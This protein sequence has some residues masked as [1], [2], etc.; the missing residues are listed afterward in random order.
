MPHWRAPHQPSS[1]PRLSDLYFLLFL[2]A[3]VMTVLLMIALWA[4]GAL[5]AEPKDVTC[6]T[7]GQPCKILVLTPQEEQLLIKPNGVLDSAA[8]GRYLDLGNIV[9]Y[10]R[11]KL[12][13]APQGEVKSVPKPADVSKPVAGQTKSVV[14]PANH[15]K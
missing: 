9:S 2:T 11:I 1:R 14:Q 12:M 15:H 13:Q 10:F 5:A 6:P 8:A 3:V 4:T 7:A